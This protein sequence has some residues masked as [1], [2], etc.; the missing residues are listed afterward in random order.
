MAI[1]RI[2][3]CVIA[4]SLFMGLSGCGT[5]KKHLMKMEKSQVDL[6]SIQ[7]RAFDSTD[8]I[9]TIRSVISVLQDLDFHI[10]EINKALGQVSAR[11][12]TDGSKISVTV[13]PNGD[14]Q[15]LVRSNMVFNQLVVEDPSVY[16]RFFTYLEK[17]LFLTAHEVD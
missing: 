16:Q 15:V 5:S 2:W 12:F 1:S 17:S 4:A 14:A 10:E 9:K 7:T 6:R 3:A 13:R 11:R 8:K